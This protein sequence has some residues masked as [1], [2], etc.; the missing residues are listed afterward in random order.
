LPTNAAS[1]QHYHYKKD[2]DLSAERAI[3]REGDERK[4]HPFNINSIDMKMV[5]MCADSEAEHAHTK[6]IPLSTR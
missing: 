1:P 2:E 5:M 4:V 6:R 3:A